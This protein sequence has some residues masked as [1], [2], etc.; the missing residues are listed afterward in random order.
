LRGI[1][2]QLEGKF[3]EAGDRLRIGRL[4]TL[5]VVLSD[6]SV[7]RRH[8]E[9]VM[10]EQGWV[11]RDL[12]STNGTFL[13]GV[14]VGP[15]ERK[16]RL[17]DVLQFGNL[18][19]VVAVLEWDAP[20]SAETPSS[21]MQV[22]AA[23]QNT[24]DQA[25]EVVAFDSGS[26]PRAGDR[27][28]TLLRAGHHLGHISNLDELLRSI[29]DDAVSALDAQRAAIVLADET[30][31]AL[32]LRA[33]STGEKETG[34]RVCF[35]RSLA[36][37]SFSSGESLLCRDVS[38]LMV[39][40]IADGAMSSIICALL[41]S[42]RKRLGVLHLDRGPFQ[43]P[44]T[45]DD[46]HLA[47]AIAASVSAAIE[48][49]QL[50]AKQQDL[51][52]QTVTALAQSVELRD[53]YTGG[54]TQRVTDYSLLLADELGVTPAER[55]RIQIGGPLHDIGKIGIDDAILRKPGK[56][57]A[58][59]FEIMKTHTIKGAAILETIPDLAPIIPI[60]RSHHERW[61]G[62]GY[63]DGLKGPD[64]PRLARIVAV[65]DAFDAMTSNRP[66]RPG[67]PVDVAFAQV[68]DGSGTQFDPE[69]AQAFLRLR[70]RV[71]ELMQQRLGSQADTLLPGELQAELEEIPTVRM[72]A[73]ATG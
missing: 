37:R 39:N 26:R 30:T 47:D 71:I 45:P 43:E 54:H 68:R 2:P 63:P 67:M 8:A 3:W 73:Q 5:E 17:R 58:G 1:G 42:P 24:W 70:P 52:I 32:E 28:L 38:D 36:Q 21:G 11:V 33:V 10:T 49:A 9:V 48:S 65:A 62:R 20:P 4:D 72:R 44:F 40:S 25:L 27:L 19:T 23:T 34:G 61:D 53:Q 35:S 41:R 14:R 50:V 13:N 57:T 29:L 64:T 12:G 66:Y 56:L 69:C 59:E 15:L 46:L 7:S 18:V 6:T 51:F 16:L 55:R 22:Q 31:G 60:V